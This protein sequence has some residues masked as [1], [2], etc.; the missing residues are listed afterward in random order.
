MVEQ[1]GHH[2]G[3]VQ[4]PPLGGLGAD[5]PGIFHRPCCQDGLGSSPDISLHIRAR[6][7]QPNT[8]NS[9]LLLKGL[10]NMP[11]W[12]MLRERTVGHKGN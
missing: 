3:A 10:R 6:Q 2:Y 4:L 7:A 5:A 11:T 1:D 8:V 9:I 12:P